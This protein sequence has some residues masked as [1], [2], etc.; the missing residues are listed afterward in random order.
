[1]NPTLSSPVM[2]R[3]H[4][5]PANNC[6]PIQSQKTT[7]SATGFADGLISPTL[8]KKKKK[9]KK[10][11]HSEM[12]SPISEPPAKTEQDTP[13]ITVE[14]RKVKKRK[15]RKRED[16]PS[17][18]TVQ[19]EGVQSHLEPSGQDEDWCL[20]EAWRLNP[21]G[22]SE[23]PKPQPQL[24]TEPKLSQA[25]EE[26]QPV[27]CETPQNHHDSTVKKKKMKKKH[28][29]KLEES[30]KHETSKRLV[31]FRSFS[32]GIPNSFISLTDIKQH[33]LVFL[34]FLE[35]LR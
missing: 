31:V 21:D 25:Q 29:E 12:D 24:T 2:S 18:M 17:S 7:E 5:C 26:I 32:A 13:E 23:R 9:K 20:G 15:K 30:I 33:F 16:E 6:G 4:P 28:K 35:K 22:S 1:M 19:G 14:T 11:H 10:R 8:K 34:P 3:I 27:L